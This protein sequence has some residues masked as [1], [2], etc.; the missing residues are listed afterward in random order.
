[1]EFF[2]WLGRPTTA[3]RTVTLYFNEVTRKNTSHSIKVEQGRVCSTQ[4]DFVL[5]LVGVPLQCAE[6]VEVA[7][8]GTTACPRKA[9]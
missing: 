3:G 6:Q 7:S 5:Q 2:S 1:M 8:S 4:S 9:S